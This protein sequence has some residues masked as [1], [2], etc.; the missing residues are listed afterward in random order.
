M[1]TPAHT[2]PIA[3]KKGTLPNAIRPHWGQSLAQL[4][5]HQHEPQARLGDTQEVSLLLAVRL[6]Q[7]PEPK[8]AK[9]QHY[10]TCTACENQT[11]QM[12]LNPQPQCH[13][14]AG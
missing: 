14:A 2:P 13:S 1:S 11:L 7:H 6:P 10:R 3:V 12:T 5:Q 4:V 9:N 8:L